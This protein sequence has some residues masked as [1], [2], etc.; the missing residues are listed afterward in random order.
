[1][2]K[3]VK[4]KEAAEVLGV[5]VR[6]LVRW[7][8]AGQ[9][10]AIKTPAGQRRYDIDSY[11]QNAS[12]SSRK[13]VLYCRVSSNAQKPYLN[14]QVAELQNLYPD[15]EIIKEVGSGLNFQRKKLLKLLSQIL[16]GE[17]E[18][19]VVSHQDRIARFGFDLFNWVCEQNHC[20]LVVL[21]SKYL[22]PETEIVEDILAILQCFSSRLYSLRKYETQIQN[23]SEIY[24]KFED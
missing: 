2:V 24:N 8:Q 10:N 18:K 19:V 1:M 17:V 6:T 15:A 7:E 13:T 11:I 3:F 21:N 12:V 14:H 22:S 16:S 20:E 23:D 9:I 4:P 5:D